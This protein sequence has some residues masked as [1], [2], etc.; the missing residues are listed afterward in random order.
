MA[1]VN[2]LS[3]TTTGQPQPRALAQHPSKPASNTTPGPL[4]F[5]PRY[6]AVVAWGGWDE[7]GGQRREGG[8]GREGILRPG[9]PWII[10]T[11]ETVPPADGA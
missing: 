11:A 2:A 5:S 10:C 1:F 9:T 7:E 4:Q 6:T 3:L 8:G